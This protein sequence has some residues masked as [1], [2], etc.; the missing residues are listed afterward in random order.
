MIL[1]THLLKPGQQ[2]A[3]IQG[4]RYEFFETFAQAMN[5]VFK[6]CII[7]SR[8]PSMFA[9]LPGPIK[10]C[11]LYTSITHVFSWLGNIDCSMVLEK[12]S[13]TFKI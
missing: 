1:I 10:L 7:I 4:F 6:K 9:E 3:N 2:L 5:D 11:W 8:Y 13:M 12:K